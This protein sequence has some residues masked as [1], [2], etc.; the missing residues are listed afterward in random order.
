MLRQKTSTP[1]DV[2]VM[3]TLQEAID[4]MPATDHLTSFGK[5]F[6]AAG[7]GNWFRERCNEAGLPLRCTAHGLRKA[8]ATR[9]ADRGATTTQLMAWFGWKTASEAER[10]TR[11]A[12]RKLAAAKAGKLIS[13]TNNGSPSDPVSQ[14]RS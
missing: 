12:G 10:C 9:L 3:P 14:K 6:T 4:E 11:S 7:S 13:G 8:A 5:P 2:P 1:F